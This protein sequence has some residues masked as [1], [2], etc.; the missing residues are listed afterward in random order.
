MKWF[1]AKDGQQVGPM[2]FSELQ[3]LRASGQ[4]SDDTLV[5]QQGT[6]NWV[7]FSEA[8]NLPAPGASGEPIPVLS[9]TPVVQTNALAITSLVLGIISLIC[10]G[11]LTGAAAAICGH[12]A[13]SQIKAN[14][15]QGGRGMALAGLIMGYIGLAISILMIVIMSIRVASGEVA[16]PHH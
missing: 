3:N 10:C 14:P 12:I 7:K 2:E 11:V 15:A 1:Y 8:L 13:I 4:I 6:A 5:W 16:L 9:P